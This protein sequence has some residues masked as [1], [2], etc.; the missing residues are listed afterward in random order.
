[1]S[2]AVVVTAVWLS[3]WITCSSSAEQQAVRDGSFME[4]QTWLLHSHKTLTYVLCRLTD[5]QTSIQWVPLKQDAPIS[6]AHSRLVPKHHTSTLK[7]AGVFQK[8]GITKRP[9]WVKNTL[10]HGITTWEVVTNDN[11]KPHS[12]SLEFWHRYMYKL[13]KQHTHT[14]TTDTPA[15]SRITAHVFTFLCHQILIYPWRAG[16]F[17]F[18][19]KHEC[20]KRL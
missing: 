4:A 10:R 12:A 6:E 16:I 13:L 3:G 1:M 9:S 2:Q 8:R 7:Q 18:S 19:F 15:H 17:L 14:A 5:R 11:P 20:R